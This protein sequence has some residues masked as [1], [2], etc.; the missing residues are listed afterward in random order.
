MVFA[1]ILVG[2]IFDDYGPAVLLGVGTFMHVFG[3]MMVS[4]STAYYQILLSQSICSGIGAS[5]VFFPAVNCVSIQFER[6]GILP[7]SSP[8]TC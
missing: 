7:S 4:I 3:L 1:G 5:M 6:D 2:K 8:D